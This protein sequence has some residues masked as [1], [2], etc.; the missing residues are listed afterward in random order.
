MPRC[1]RCFAGGFAIG[2][3]SAALSVWTR[4]VT[5]DLDDP[6]P[7]AAAEGFRL[8]AAL[9]VLPPPN[10]AAAILSLDVSGASQDGQARLLIGFS[11]SNVG[12]LNMPSA[13]SAGGA[14]QGS[15]A[16]PAEVEMDGAGAAPS[17]ASAAAAEGQGALC[18]FLSG[19]AHRG[20]VTSLDIAVQ[21]PIIV[22]ASRQECSVRVWNYASK[23]CELSWRFPGEEPLAVAMH[24]LGFLA[25]V[26]FFDKIRVVQVLADELKP[27]R[28]ISAKGVRLL[29][30]SNGGHLLAAAKGRDVLVLSSRTLA[31]VG[32]GR[33]GC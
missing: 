4:R 21:R 31:K 23:E 2:G 8:V 12:L 1:V 16:A 14:G 6:L 18:E 25:A 11:D 3:D 22:T 30:F 28:L 27:H 5:I 20:P 24:P 19:G 10:V 15:V 29:K 13:D 17:V 7:E 33:R 32:N 9:C 26:A